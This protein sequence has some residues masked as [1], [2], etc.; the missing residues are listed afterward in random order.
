MVD[1]LRL[2]PHNGVLLQRSTGSSMPLSPPAERRHLHTRR[3][4]CEGYLRTDGLWD[5]E[6]EITDTKTYPS[7]TGWRG[8]LE[9]GDPIHNMRVRLTLT[10]RMEIVAAEADTR[11]SPY[12]ICPDAADNFAVLVG[13]K[14]GPGWM[15]DVKQ[16]YGGAHGCTH[17]L[18]LLGQMA[19]TAY[20]TIFSWREKVK[21][22][23]GASDAEI[24]RRG[25][26]PD[27]C[28]AYGSDR[29]VMQDIRAAQ[30]AAAQQADAAD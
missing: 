11:K 9:P 4:V 13:V 3:I 25:P 30:A 15:R 6:A 29:E 20:Q 14:I 8:D 2:R 22:D 7:H 19:T 24:A 10:N 5:I 1:R 28:W 16:R 23:A 17:I 21:R 27:S 18:E 26:A 12:K